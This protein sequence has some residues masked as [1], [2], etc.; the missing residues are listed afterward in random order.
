M[1]CNTQHTTRFYTRGAARVVPASD[2][3]VQPDSD[4]KI[5]HWYQEGMY[6]EAGPKTRSAQLSIDQL[7]LFM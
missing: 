7:F 5:S 1:L 2:K 3:L 4:E 6:D